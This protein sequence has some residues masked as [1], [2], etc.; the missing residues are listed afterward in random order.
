MLSFSKIRK[1]R[2][3]VGELQYAARE[4]ANGTANASDEANAIRNASGWEGVSGDAAK[5]ALKSLVSTFDKSSLDDHALASKLDAEGATVQGLVDRIDAL[6]QECKSSKPPFGVNENEEGGMPISGPDTRGM[7]DEQRTAVINK[8]ADLSAKATHILTEGEAADKNLAAVISE[9][10]SKHKLVGF[11]AGPEA[12][13]PAGTEL[14]PEQKIK[15]HDGK[16][17]TGPDSLKPDE[18]G[19]FAPGVKGKSFGDD[20]KV[21]PPKGPIVSKWDGPNKEGAQFDSGKKTLDLPGGLKYE[22]EGKALS[23]QLTSQF[24]NHSDGVLSH[25]LVTGDLLHEDAK[26]TVPKIGP[27][28]ISANGHSG[29]GV[30]SG[31]DFTKSQSGFSTGVEG[32]VGAHTGNDV[33]VDLYGIGLHDRLDV[34]AGGGVAGGLHF[35]MDGDKFRVGAG[36]G[37]AWLLGGKN[38]VELTVS[39]KDVASNF[40]KFVHWLS[41]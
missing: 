16:F 32:M 19:Q 12:T 5:H 1:L 34:Y 25:N 6:T 40:H 35:G 22:W 28:E 3:V 33:G 38:T 15:D 26:L 17:G 29:V 13:N 30:E 27:L 8:Y 10:T 14:L 23:G 36:A 20:L 37:A 39:P 9:S 21:D 31:L 41:E 7:S 2:A 24:E 18:K 11:Q 4:R